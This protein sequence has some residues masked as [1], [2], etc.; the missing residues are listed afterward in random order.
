LTNYQWDAEGR[1]KSVNN[2]ALR[3]FIYNALGRE[4]EWHGDGRVS[5][6]L[7]DLAGHYLGSVDPSTGAW[8]GERIP[9]SSI[10][11]AW[12]VNGGTTFFHYN[13][14]GSSMMN[15][16]QDGNTV[17]NDVLFYPWGQMWASPVNDYFQFFGNIEGWDWEIGEGVTPNRYYPNYQ[18]RWLS[19]DPL[20]GN[21]S[22]PQSLNRY[23]YVLNNPTTLID[24]TGLDCK[25]GTANCH[26][27]PPC[28]GM[29]CADQYYGGSFFEGA[30]S[31]FFAICLKNGILGYC[32]QGA[33]ASFS[34]GGNDEFDAIAGAPGTSFTP[35]GQT[36][37]GSNG[38][39]STGTGSAGFDAGA[40]MQAEGYIDYQNS[41][42]PNSAPT[43]GYGTILVYNFA[44]GGGNGTFNELLSPMKHT[45]FLSMIYNVGPDQKTTFGYQGSI[46]TFNWSGVTISTSG[47]AVVITVV[48]PYQMAHPDPNAPLPP[49]FYFPAP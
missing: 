49:T 13:A 16:H 1:L 48:T 10:Y 25:P 18:G 39:T 43:T 31:T 36:Q 7:T 46:N 28:N 6:D 38:R 37:I 5:E 34:A 20:A 33:L 44:E 9:G 12:Y 8:T 35:A 2:G 47:G 23:A 22:N 32:N 40:W 14:L 19:P 30:T 26:R 24:P 21:I 15:T 29:V 41:Q 45:N 3:S 42:K 27:P 17:S 11:L 4:A